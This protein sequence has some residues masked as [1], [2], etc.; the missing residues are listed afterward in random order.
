MAFGKML[1]TSLIGFDAEAM[2]IRP[3]GAMVGFLE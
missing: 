3:G 1:R 2:P